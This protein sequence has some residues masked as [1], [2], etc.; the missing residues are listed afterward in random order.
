MSL[1]TPPQIERFQRKLYDKAKS[2]PE[3]RFYQLYDKVY[4]PDILAHAYAVCQHNAGAPGVDGLTFTDIESRGLA[5]WLEGLRKELREGTYK[6]QPVRRVMIPKP[7][8]G[9]RPL[10]IPTIRDRVVQTAAKLILEPIFEA[11]LDEAAH[12]YRPGRSAGEAIAKVH[13]ALQAGQTD[14]VDADLSKYFDTIPHHELLR[15]VARRVVDRHMLRLIRMWLKTPVEEED[16]RGNKRY[17][18]GRQSKVGTPQGGVISPLLANLYMN[19]YLRHFKQQGKDVAFQATLINYADDFVILCRGKARAA[20][21]WTQQVMGKLKLTLNTTKTCIR[22]ARNETFNF[23]GYTFGPNYHRRTGRRYLGA[24]PSAKSVKRV[25]ENVS[26]L[27]CPGNQDPL[28]RVVQR[29][30]AR[31][32]GWANYFA[33]G[34]P[35]GAYKAVDYHVLQRVQS[36]LRRRHKMRSNGRSR[37]NSCYVEREL[38]VVNLLGALMKRRP[39]VCRS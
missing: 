18:G 27:L 39:L 1:Q 3:F 10:G 8:G 19:R 26:T 21:D 36:F 4:R 9:Q 25:K 20:L 30:N 34:R 13:A 6:P 16:E 31:L 5:G 23:L 24:W 11:D 14:V 33:Y 7:G 12:G 15:S 38:G 28:E 17:T 2:E 29:L 35:Y 22:D 37:F 32:R